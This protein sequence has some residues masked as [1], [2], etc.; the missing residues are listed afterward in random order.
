M[1][2]IGKGAIN[3]FIT[4]KIDYDVMPLYF[5]RIFSECERESDNGVESPDNEHRQHSD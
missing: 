1:T 4:D 2:Y 5:I 3:G